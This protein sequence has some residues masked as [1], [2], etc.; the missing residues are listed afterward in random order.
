MIYT[1]YQFLLTECKPIYS[2]DQLRLLVQIGGLK[3]LQ[4]YYE[5]VYSTNSE[6]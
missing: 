2:L 4:L 3:T 6:H 5:K 1:N